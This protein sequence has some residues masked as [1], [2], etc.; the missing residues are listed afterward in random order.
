MKI[1]VNHLGGPL[2]LRRSVVE[3]A[4]GDYAK[5]R[6]TGLLEELFSTPDEVWQVDLPMPH[7]AWRYVKFL[8]QGVLF[9]I[10]DVARFDDLQ[11]VDWYFMELDATSAFARYQSADIAAQR[12]GQLNYSRWRPELSL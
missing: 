5:V 6:W 2:R 8:P 11:I 4:L 7:F 1:L 10:V 3:G 12:T 9:G